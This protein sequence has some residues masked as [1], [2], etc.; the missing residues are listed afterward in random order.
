M[1]DL[2]SS[3]RLGSSLLRLGPL[4][5]GAAPLGNLYAPVSDSDA[6]ATLAAA[7]A[8][9]I[10]WFDVAP[11]YGYGLAEKRVGHYLQQ[12]PSTQQVLSTKVGRILQPVTVAQTHQHF[13]APLPY[14]P[15][16]DYSR[17]GIERS[18]EESLCRLRRSRVELLLLHDVDRFSHPV[19]HRALVKLLLDES[20]PALQRL[21]EE[22]R[23]DAI[24]LGINEWD[25]GY[26]ILA[27]TEIDAVL[28]AGRYTLLD[29]TAFSSGFLDTCARKCVSVLAGG[30]FNSGFLA[31][32]TFYN[33]GPPVESLVRRRERLTTICARYGVPLPAVALQ[34]T[35][36]H[37]AVT[38]VVVGAR[39]VPEINA[40][41]EWSSTV[42]P[43][44]LW[45]EL[46]EDALIPVDTP[47]AS[48]SGA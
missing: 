9:G 4:G 22:G 15:M 20:L 43:S 33:Y 40:I 36:A 46:R 34:F 47:C 5:L 6:E 29:Q 25:V 8:H 42:I 21:K 28:L 48:G 12:F 13:V 39:S 35:A 2:R 17:Q 45:N 7:Q 31:G 30:V 11:L 37:P 44:A 16:F 32:G 19:G 27:S 1:I 38:S 24:G 3:R 18:Y 41:A 14:E 10:S 26:E 23:V